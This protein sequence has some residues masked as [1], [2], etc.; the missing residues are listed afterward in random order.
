MNFKEDEAT[1]EFIEER[2]KQIYQKQ[3]PHYFI[4]VKWNIINGMKEKPR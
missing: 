2:L 4:E 3:N 1:P